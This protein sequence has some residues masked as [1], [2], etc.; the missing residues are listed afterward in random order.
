[1]ANKRIK[2]SELPPISYA[3]TA[4]ENTPSIKDTD[5]FPVTV[6][7]KA[8]ATVKK[9]M[10]ITSEEMRRYVLQQLPSTQELTTEDGIATTLTIAP[11]LTVRIGDL[12]ADSI[13]YNTLQ[14]SG[15]GASQAMT[16]LEVVS[17]TSTN[18]IRVG[19]GTSGSIYPSIL[20]NTSNEI[21]SNGLLVAND[22]G[23]FTGKGTSLQTLLAGTGGVVTKASNSGKLVTVNGTGK[24]EFNQSTRTVLRNSGSISSPI[25]SA[26]IDAI[27]KVGTD[28]S[29]AP[30]TNITATDVKAAV[31]RTAVE[32]TGASATDQ[33]FL[34]TTAGSPS[35]DDIKIAS[36]AHMKLV[37]DVSLDDNATNNII[38]NG[39]E[40]K[41]VVRS[42]LVL[43]YKHKDGDDL[44]DRAISQL[45][46]AVVGEIRWNLFNSIP[47]LYLA[48]S[49]DATSPH[50]GQYQACNWYGVPLFGTIDDSISAGATGVAGSSYTDL[51]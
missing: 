26:E 35:L 50:T 10:S 27:L 47:T 13:T 22:G 2:I 43:G 25:G 38:V 9:T 5:T 40:A 12:S 41:V 28:G 33:K 24:F 15:E 36:A 21:V 1:M 7:S 3:R 14:S 34:V 51:D 23:Y 20:Y 19:G 42:P 4:G 46:P 6:S 29:I 32:F 39:N 30:D 17:L 44:T 45:V 49:V 8:D 16:S 48:V 37:T 18:A 31:D 11:G